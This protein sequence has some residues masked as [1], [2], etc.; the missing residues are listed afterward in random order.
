M[1]HYQV[2]YD[3]WF[4]EGGYCQFYPIKN[5]KTLGFKEFRNKNLAK[6]AYQTQ[7]KLAKFDLAPRLYSEVCKLTFH[8]S[9]D[10]WLPDSTDWG[11]VTEIAGKVKNIKQ[12]QTLDKIQELVENIF[13]KTKL[14][15]WDC[16]YYNIGIVKRNGVEKF[17]CID[18]GKESFSSTINAWSNIDPGP[19]CSY[20]LTY[21]CKCSNF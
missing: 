7:K 6:F 3:S 11:Y 12:I 8:K 20:C 21:E 18:T 13:E 1:S 4:Q 17:V 19:R 14:K 9:D 16:H 5:H 15:F 10:N 2:D